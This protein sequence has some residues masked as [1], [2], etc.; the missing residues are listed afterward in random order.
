METPTRVLSIDIGVVSY[1]FCIVDFRH[2]DFELVHIEKTAIG[3]IKQTAHALTEALVDFLRSS[4][5]INEKPIAYIYI[6]NQ[7]SRAIK[8]TVLAYATMT[9]FYTEA[10][11]AQSDVQIRFVAP[12]AKFQAI[13][14]YF[15]G[16]VESQDMVLRSN[17]KDLKKL[18]VRIARSVFT[19]LNVT[20]GLEAIQKY[21]PKLDDVCDVFLQSFAVFLDQYRGDG[22]PIRSSRRSLLSRGK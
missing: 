13:D 8:N 4:D 9:Y 5:A 3:S 1:S 22:N 21:R 19:E 14:A 15:P 20:K 2:D 12:R 16:A 10:C 7:L 6:E 11:I 17:S 18:S